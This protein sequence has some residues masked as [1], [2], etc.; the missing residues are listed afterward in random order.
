MK[1]RTNLPA[2]FALLLFAILALPIGNALAQD[3]K[4]IAGTY[5]SVLN[6]AFGDNPRGQ[7]ILG[8]DGHYSII[9]ARA[10]L[11]KSAPSSKRKPSNTP[12]ERRSAYVLINSSTCHGYFSS[13][14]QY[15]IFLLA[16]S[17]KGESVARPRLPN[18]LSA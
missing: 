14:F 16:H 1:N 2:A 9:L 12:P 10:T 6:S 7:M 5:S 15:E 11:K 3:A 13:T 17:F 8:L 4:S 18:L